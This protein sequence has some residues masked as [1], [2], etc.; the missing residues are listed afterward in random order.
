MIKDPEAKTHQHMS[1][2]FHLVGFDDVSWKTAQTTGALSYMPYSRAQEYAALYG[3][4]DDFD[5]A[6]KQAVRDA[7]VSIGPFLNEDVTDPAA[8]SRQYQSIKERL[9]VLQGQLVLVESLV[10]GLDAEYK[11][12]LAAHPN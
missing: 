9:E 5:V 7:I 3:L 1:V 10:T 2:N 12:F 4:Q 8:A 11:K 6:Q